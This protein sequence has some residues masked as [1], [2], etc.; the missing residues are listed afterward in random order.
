MQPGMHIL[1]DVVADI[2]AQRSGRMQIELHQVDLGLDVLADVGPS[3][4]ATR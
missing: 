4:S 3:M 2:T 1:K